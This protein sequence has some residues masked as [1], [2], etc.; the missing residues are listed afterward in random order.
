[1]K[2]CLIGIVI[3]SIF[4]AFGELRADKVYTWTDEKG[5]LHITQ[6]PPPKRAKLKDTMDYLP[7]PEKKDL[8]TVRRQEI[9]DKAGLKIQKSD[10]ARKA[11][12]EAQK[13]RQEAEM[14][15]FKAREAARK[16]EEYRQKGYAYRME[17]A[18]EDA[19]A[20]RERA[21][22]AE[23]KAIRT[24]KKARIAEEMARQ[25]DD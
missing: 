14:A 25:V 15:R 12:A 17:K 23:E 2:Y 1:M 7:R 6:H 9:G 10:G 22:I 13:A 19:K 16:A 20:A 8:E 24:E 4:T 11:R 21:K 5:N 18:A 3:V